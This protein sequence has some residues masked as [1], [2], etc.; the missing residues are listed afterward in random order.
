MNSES[1]EVSGLRDVFQGVGSDIADSESKLR[2]AS[3]S[4][5]AVGTGI[6]NGFKLPL[7]TIPAVALEALQ[8][9]DSPFATGAVTGAIFGTWIYGSSGII[10]AAGNQYPEAKERAMD[11]FSGKITHLS[12]SLPGL[13]PEAPDTNRSPLRRFGTFALNHAEIG[14]TTVG[15]GATPYVA[16]AQIEKQSRPEIRKIRR[17]VSTDAAIA[18]GSLSCL[19]AVAVSELQDSHPGWADFIEHTATDTK[20]LLAVALG[21]VGTK[22]YKVIKKARK[23]NSSEVKDT[24]RT[25]EAA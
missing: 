2:I 7:I 1:P 5:L 6:V 3:L 8:Y 22:A 17:M 12:E 24:D 23:K 16:I 13:H 18:I 10:D 19:S 21:I 20:T 15:I 9:T 25:P 4:A 11:R 14:M